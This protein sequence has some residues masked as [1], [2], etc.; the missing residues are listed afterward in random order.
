ML[1]HFDFDTWRR[2]IWLAAHEGNPR[3]RCKLYLRLLVKIPLIALFNAVCF[4]LDPL[5]FPGLRRVEVRQPVFVIGHARSGTTLMHRLL[6]ADGERFSAFLYWE[7]FAP[8]V[9][10]KKAVHWLARIDARWLGGRLAKWVD[11]R[12]QRIFG[13]S[14]HIHRMGYRLPEEDDFMLTNS[15]ASG[16]WMTELPYL[17]QLDFYH[18]DRRPEPRRR[19]LMGFYRECVRRQLYVNGDNR[20]HLSKNPTFCGR[21]ETL[22]E[23]FPDARFVLLYRNP[24]ETMPS[25]LKLMKFSWSAR[26]FDEARMQSSLRALAELSF[27]N[28]T[29]PLEVLE[30]H[31]GTP[32][33]IVDYRQLVAEPKRTVGEVYA[34]LGLEVG[35][36]YAAVLDA[37]Q[38]RAGRHETTH[39]Y[40][41]AEFGLDADEI[42]R[43]LAPLFQRFGWERD[44]ARPAPGAD[45]DAG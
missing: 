15:C 11:A 37:E 35:A 44:A 2:L 32:R 6:S 31:P 12:E 14:N 27:H 19:R 38:A 25:L 36:Q 26:H 39:S 40:S 29:Y 23:V 33:A 3:R 20:I 9:L 4:A 28:Y 24:L 1:F 22:L 18:I 42:R 10:Q 7:L 8:S 13:P 21:V 5:L 16:Y 45:A 43:R 34:A 17:G 41:L 30:R